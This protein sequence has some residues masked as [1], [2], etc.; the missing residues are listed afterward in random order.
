MKDFCTRVL[1]FAVLVAFRLSERAALREM[2][3]Q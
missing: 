1:G 3:G 2:P